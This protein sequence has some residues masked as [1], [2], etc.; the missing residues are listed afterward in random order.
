MT[1]IYTPAGELLDKA[2][3]LTR[4]Q[5]TDDELLRDLLALNRN[6]AQPAP[7]GDVLQ[8]CNQALIERDGRKPGNGADLAQRVGNSG[9][10]TKF[11]LIADLG[12]LKEF[13]YLIDQ[14]ILRSATNTTAGCWPAARPQN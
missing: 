9:T 8:A 10:A 6:A 3:R 14:C 1:A 11:T 12:E 5:T 13:E 4:S 2:R 7:R